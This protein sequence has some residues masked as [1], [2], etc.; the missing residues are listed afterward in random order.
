MILIKFS[1][2]R[3]FKKKMQKTQVDLLRTRVWNGLNVKNRSNEVSL[4]KIL[5]SMNISPSCYEDLL[6]AGRGP[7]FVSL[8]LTM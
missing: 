5:T 7:K 8:P 4:I 3:I 2:Q 1:E 6:I